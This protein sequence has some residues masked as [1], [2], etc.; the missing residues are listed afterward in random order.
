MKWLLFIL[1]FAFDSWAQTV[2]RYEYDPSGNRVAGPTSV[3][4]E[5]EKS[6]RVRSINGGAIP[7]ERVEER[8]IRSDDQERVVER[9]VQRFDPDGRPAATLRVVVEEKKLPGGGSTIRTTAYRSNASGRS[10]LVE[11]TTSQI[12]KSGDSATTETT[13]ERPSVNGSLEPAERRTTVERKGEGS[14]SSTTAVY[15]PDTNGRFVEAVRESS[16]RHGSGGQISESAARYEPDPLTGQMRLIESTERST[17]KRADGSESE[18]VDVYAPQTPGL[19]N[20]NSKPK[21][22]EQQ[23]IERR[24]AA[25]GMV[26]TLAVRRPGLNDPNRLGPARKV[27]ETVCTGKCQ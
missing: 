24:P 10:D 15:R 7:L 25:G 22:K 26:E 21:I 18:V 23:I 20:Q 5:G 4:R 13:V 14:G 8:V 27:S 2:Q 19:A 12:S 11:R 9:V 16:E 17:V 6:V 1:M 3:A